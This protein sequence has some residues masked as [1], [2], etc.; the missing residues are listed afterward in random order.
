M[1]TISSDNFNMS[2]KKALFFDTYEAM[3][4]VTLQFLQHTAQY[5][6]GARVTLGNRRGADDMA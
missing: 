5:R 3:T 2:R 6:S 4:A 1:E